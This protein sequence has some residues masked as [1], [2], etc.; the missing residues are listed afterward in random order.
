MT[1][2]VKVFDYIKTVITNQGYFKEFDLFNNQFE[3]EPSGEINS[4]KWPACFVELG[5]IEYESYE[6][7]QKG[8]FNIIFHVGTK[9]LKRD[10]TRIF[11]IADKIQEAFHLLQ[12]DDF[13]FE[14]IREGQVTNLTTI[15]Q[16][17]IEYKVSYFDR[18]GEKEY[19]LLN[20]TP[21]LEI[22][23]ETT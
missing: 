4:F 1:G 22:T 15:A 17:E 12:D 7:I 10:P 8:E 14:R 13:T 3:K 6:K 9:W 19:T 2:K 16:W 5:S 20:T 23:K 11:E 18:T 21:D